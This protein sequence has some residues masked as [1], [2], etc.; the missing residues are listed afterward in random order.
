MSSWS[1][2]SKLWRQ[3]V[4]TQDIYNVSEQKKYFDLQGTSSI[5]FWVS[6]PV[7]HLLIRLL[8]L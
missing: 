1:I 5:F 6:K 3:D 4:R 2:D 7:E 8:T